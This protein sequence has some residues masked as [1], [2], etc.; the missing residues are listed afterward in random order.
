MEDSSGTATFRTAP[1]PR[2]TS[3]EVL[4]NGIILDL[5]AADRDALQIL[6]WDKSGKSSIAP[7]FDAGGGKLY[8]PPHVEPSVREAIM[9]P[10]GVAEYGTVP[11]LFMKL[12]GLC[13]EHVGLPED[14]AAFAT[15]WILSTWI[16]ELLLIPFTLCICA[17]STRQV[18]KWFRLLR[19][20]CRRSLLVAEL[21]RRLPL[22][23]NPT[24]IINDPTLSISTCTF[25]RSANCHGVYVAGPGGTLSSL[26][27]PKAIALQPGDFPQVWGEEAMVIMLPD[28]ESPPLRQAAL[29]SIADELQP[30]L[31]MFRLRRLS[32]MDQFVSPTHPLSRFELARNLGPC[33]P[34]DPGIVRVLTP[35]LESHEQNIAAQ[36]SCDPE[37][38]ILEA[39]W[40]PSHERE[41]MAVGEIAK[42]ANAILRSR[43]VTH[44]Y[45]VREIGWKL[46][47]L[48]MH[49]TSNGRHKVLR[50]SVAVRTRLHDYVRKPGPQLPFREDCADC[51][52]LQAT[53]KK[54][55]K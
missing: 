40:T 52:A 54:P 7:V 48:S 13:R 28:S 24:L 9:F 46:R 51:Q 14:A 53:D 36:R 22:F 45:S 15:C 21:S 3:G 29:M 39:I 20:L 35:L 55:D 8:G 38:A 32:G 18:Y 47:A 16:P 2:T 5:V 42:R 25:W 33:I 1:L 44:E 12:S 49:T 26:C 30:Q 6:S 19:S 50:F 11:E 27:C 34:E 10:K 23:L 31:E 17:G 37:V 4:E 41:E 43:G